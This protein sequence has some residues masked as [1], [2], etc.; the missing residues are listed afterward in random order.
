VSLRA[1]HLLFISAAALLALGLGWWCLP[2]HPAGLA[3]AVVV[4]AGLAVYEAWFLRKTR[5]LT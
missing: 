1:F 2:E 5:R 4:A 3:A